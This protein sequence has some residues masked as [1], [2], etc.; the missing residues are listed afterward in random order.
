LKSADVWN[1]EAHEET[2]MKQVANNADFLLGP[3]F[4]PED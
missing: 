2:S 4:G 1:E 3:I